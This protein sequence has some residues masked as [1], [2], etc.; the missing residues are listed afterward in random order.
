L[1]FLTYDDDEHKMFMQQLTIVFRYSKIL[2]AGRLNKTRSAFSHECS[3][4]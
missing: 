1:D 4:Y 3:N 2:M